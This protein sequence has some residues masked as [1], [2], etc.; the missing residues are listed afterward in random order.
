MDLLSKYVVCVLCKNILKFPVLLPCKHSICKHHENQAAEKMDGTRMIE[1][2]TCEKSFKIPIDGF[3]LTIISTIYVDANQDTLIKE[4]KSMISDLSQQVTRILDDFLEI[5]QNLEGRIHRVIN[6]IRKNIVNIAELSVYDFDKYT[7]V[8]KR[9][10]YFE[11]LCKS[12]SSSVE[13]NITFVREVV[14]KITSFESDVQQLVKPPITHETMLKW[15][16]ISDILL[17]H[18]KEL[19]YAF[20][21][22][23]EEIFLYHMNGFNF[24]DLSDNSSSNLEILEKLFI[25]Y[26]RLLN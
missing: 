12:N 26:N 24:S 4:L 15:R 3:P 10:D 2:A 7:K 8:M 9:I 20:N 11:K 18:L 14:N 22:Y 16:Q 17:F 1:C 5:D 25:K 23:N 6:V 19:Q 13:P 21:R